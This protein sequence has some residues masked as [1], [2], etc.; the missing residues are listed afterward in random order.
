MFAAV[1]APTPPSKT[2]VRLEN[3]FE[4]KERDHQ[5]S[6]QRPASASQSTHPERESDNCMLH[7]LQH[8][9][10]CLFC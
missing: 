3:V 10:L 2:S 5:A 7:R 1:T 4:M 9:V 6:C 8:L